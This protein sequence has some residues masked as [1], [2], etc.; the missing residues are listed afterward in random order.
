MEGAQNLR[1]HSMFFLTPNSLILIKLG[2]TNVKGRKNHERVILPSSVLRKEEWHVHIVCL[3]NGLHIILTTCL[4]ERKFATE[5]V[6]FVICDS[7]AL[8]WLPCCIL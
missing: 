1:N 7:C 3:G 2:R 6:D 8:L 4:W 5:G